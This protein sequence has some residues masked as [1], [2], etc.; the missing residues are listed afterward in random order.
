[1]RRRSF[2]AG[3]LGIFVAPVV[4]KPPGFADEASATLVEEIEARHAADES[5]DQFLERRRRLLAYRNA[6]SI[7]TLALTPKPPWC[8]SW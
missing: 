4:A 8:K 7:E 6:A 1:M 5:F 2:L 3:F